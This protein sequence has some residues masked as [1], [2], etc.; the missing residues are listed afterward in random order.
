MEKF[1]NI[2]KKIDLKKE[3]LIYSSTLLIL[4]IF[5]LIYFWSPLL[6]GFKNVRDI[7]YLKP[8]FLNFETE[9]RYGN[10]ENENKEYTFIYNEKTFIVIRQAYNAKNE[11]DMNYLIYDTDKSFTLKGNNHTEMFVADKY[12]YYNYGIIIK[13]YAWLTLSGIK[14]SHTP[15][16]KSSYARINLAELKENERIS[17][18]EFEDAYKAELDRLEE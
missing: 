17:R 7:N 5:S 9:D 11:E 13:R 18:T 4:L 16:Q 1:F 8:V 12:L 15:M 3:L 6:L 10:L 2:I 14:P